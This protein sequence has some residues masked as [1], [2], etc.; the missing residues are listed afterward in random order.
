[1]NVSITNDEIVEDTETVTLGLSS[2]DGQAVV[3]NNATLSIMDND[4]MLVSATG[5]RDGAF[6]ACKHTFP[7]LTVPY[8][9][10]RVNTL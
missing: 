4:G 5:L 6:T 10:A 2:T 1:M 3:T 8:S 9:S 7:N